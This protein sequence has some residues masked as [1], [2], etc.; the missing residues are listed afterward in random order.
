[1]LHVAKVE[2]AVGCC[3]SDQMD[4]SGSEHEKNFETVQTSCCDGAAHHVEVLCGVQGSPDHYW[5]VY[6]DSAPESKGVS[7]HLYKFFTCTKRS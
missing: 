1:M 4:E 7:V 6:M 3:T 5:S 2:Q